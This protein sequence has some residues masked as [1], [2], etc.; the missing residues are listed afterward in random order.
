MDAKILIG[1]D[2]IAF[3]HDKS[4]ERPVAIAGAKFPATRIVELVK[5]ADHQLL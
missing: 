1:E 5:L 3:A 2:S 4:L